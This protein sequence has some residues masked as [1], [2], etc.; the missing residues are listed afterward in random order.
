MTVRSQGVE[1]AEVHPAVRVC[2]VL[3]RAHDLIVSGK[4]RRIAAAVADAGFALCGPSS[5][6]L[7]RPGC[8]EALFAALGEWQRM[9]FGWGVPP[10]LAVFDEAK[11]PEERADLVLLAGRIAGWGVPVDLGS[12]API[13]H[14]VE[15]AVEGA[16]AVP[17]GEEGFAEA[18]R[19]GIYRA[20]AAP[21][22]ALMERGRVPEPSDP[23][24]P[25]R[26]AS[27]ALAIVDEA[28]ETECICGVWRAPDHP[29]PKHGK[30][31]PPDPV[32]VGEVI[33]GVIDMIRTAEPT[34][35]KPGLVQVRY[36][37]I[38]DGT[39]AWVFAAILEQA[40]PDARVV[41][42]IDDWATGMFGIAVRSM[43]FPV[44]PEGEC[45]P[46]VYAKLFD[47]TRQVQVV[48]PARPAADHL[49][50]E[51]ADDAMFPLR[52]WCAIC[53]THHESV[54]PHEA[55]P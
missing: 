22:S 29:C 42:V 32:P 7:W 44:V 34:H 48:W 40:P 45:A 17:N 30:L 50:P 38:M 53:E 25:G 5:P 51:L 55:L 10:L 8:D 9:A 24:A 2:A 16:F 6:E 15:A 13:V 12:I 3:W 19:E 14:E 27:D 36:S 39:P 49:H 35:A 4:R 37:R 28:S 47:S 18:L 26:R 52:P 43:T 23:I 11:T 21:E 1:A 31:Y 33:P 41:G 46:I 20:L 54:D